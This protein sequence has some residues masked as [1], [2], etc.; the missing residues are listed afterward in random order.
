MD[1]R[2]PR[3]THEL[4][5]TVDVAILGGGIAGLATA[6]FAHRAGLTSV[7]IERRTALASLSTSAATGGFRL[8]FDNPHEIATVRESLEF[9][10]RF[11]SETGLADWDLGWMPQGYLL[12][13]FEAAT[14]ARQRRRV[15]AQRAWGVTDVELLDAREV[16]VRWP[17][18]SERV[19]SATYRA[20]DGWLDPKR[21]AIGYAAASGEPC[22]MGTEVHGFLESGQRITGLRTSRG[23]LSAGAI[24][25]AAGPFSGT[26]AQLAGVALPISPTRRYRLILPDVPEAPADAPMTIDEESGA[27]WRP[28]RGGAHGMW[29]RPDVPSEAPLDD[30]P[31]SDAFAFALL[32][33]A[34]PAALAR[35]SPFWAGVWRRQSLHWSI[36]AGQY[37]DTPDRRP[38]LGASSRAGLFVNTG[39]SGHGVMSSAACARIT[40][41]AIRG[42]L[43]HEANPFRFDRIFEPADP[44]SL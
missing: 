33:P 27:H 30:V 1:P 44:A 13:A 31:P 21:L 19:I 23:D 6:F 2:S 5:R 3:L 32:D 17:W 39:H 26:I 16:R 41:D 10:Q 29:T 28:W 14:E 4:P 15:E 8:Q 43:A 34:S 42:V 7:V 35:L 18:L 12:C 36:R 9:Y 25:L 40:V 20:G 22:V 11:E 37:D 38:L 24:V